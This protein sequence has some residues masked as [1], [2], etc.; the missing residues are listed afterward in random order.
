MDKRR[1]AAAGRAYWFMAVLLLAWSTFACLAWGLTV[2]REGAWL[3]QVS[4]EVV[5]WLDGLPTWSILSSALCTW[6]GLAGALLLLARSRRAVP[7]FAASLLGLML[8]QTLQFGADDV[9]PG[10]ASPRALA[11]DLAVWALALGLLWHAIQRQRGG[12]LR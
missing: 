12:V 6:S 7:A 3:S 2:T 8:T 10:L 1:R 5:D 4:P 11:F 9:P